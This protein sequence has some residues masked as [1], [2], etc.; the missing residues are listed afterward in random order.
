MSEKGH[1]GGWRLARPLEAVTLGQVHAALGEPGLLPETP[2]VEAEGC[3]IEAAVN[4]ALSDTYA[5]ARALLAAR[6][7]SITL[8]DLAADFSRRLA[9]HPKRDLLHAHARKSDA[10]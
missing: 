3:L 8:A 10:S 6:L 2:P 4:D 1:G 9:A 5:A 7:D